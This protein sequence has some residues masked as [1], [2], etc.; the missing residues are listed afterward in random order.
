MKQP[1]MLIAFALG[2]GAVLVA[3]PAPAQ[4]GPPGGGYVGPPISLCPTVA[5]SGVG[6]PDDMGRRSF[7]AARSADLIFHVLFDRSLEKDHVVTLK[8]FTPHGYLYRRLDVPLAPDKGE[9]PRGARRLPGYPYPV[10]VKAPHA[11]TV[12]G[13]RYESVDV[14]FPVAG[15]TIVTSSLYGRWKVEIFLDGAAKPCGGPTFFDLGQ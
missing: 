5:V 4:N 7:S 8:I 15:S 3:V 6:N 13:R 1:T 11:V 9:E 2:L 12:G 10:P 14:P